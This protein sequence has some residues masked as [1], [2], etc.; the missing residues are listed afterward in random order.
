MMEVP[1]TKTVSTDLQW[2][3]GSEFRLT[4]DWRIRLLDDCASTNDIAL[5][6]ARNG[7]SPGLV[8]VA[9]SQHKGRGRLG[10][11][12]HSPADM[13]IYL[14]ILLQPQIAPKD[15]PKVTITAGLAVCRAM[16]MVTGLP[17]KL[18]WPNDLFIERKKI[19]GILCESLPAAAGAPMF[20]VIGI[21]INVGDPE[22][23]IPDEIRGK[24]AS[25]QQAGAP[26]LHRGKLI[27]AILE[28]MSFEISRLE[29]NHFG[30]ILSEWRLRDGFAEAQ[31]TWVT[32]TGD[33]VTGI[34]HGPDED[35]LLRITDRYGT[36]HIVLS[37]DLEIVP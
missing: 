8:V 30:E 1:L 36:T 6:A 32:A 34:S 21:G 3:T 25:L 7:S 17:I 24:A 20:A 37:G 18:K 22:G 5:S 4:G 29:Q 35:G 9:A 19:G 14:S 28:Q 16:E 23:M 2:L 12:W 31:L 10:R 26:M 11:S 13:G 33:R 15:L 27:E